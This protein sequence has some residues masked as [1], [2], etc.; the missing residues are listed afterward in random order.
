MIHM[1]ERYFLI[2]CLFGFCVALAAQD[3]KNRH[4]YT[5]SGID[6]GYTTVPT[7]DNFNFEFEQNPGNMEE[8]FRAGLHVLRSLYRDTSI[9]PSSKQQYVRERAQCFAL[10]ASFHS[11][12]LCIFPNDASADRK[13]ERFRGFTT[14]MPNWKWIAVYNVLPVA[15]VFGLIFYFSTKKIQG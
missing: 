13:R 8:R 11:Y 4:V 14:Q 7:G 2:V 1:I 9:D 5:Q 3:G 12:S 15:L 10:D 6:F